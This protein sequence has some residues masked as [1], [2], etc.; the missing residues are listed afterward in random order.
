MYFVIIQDLLLLATLYQ[1]VLVVLIVQRTRAYPAG[2]NLAWYLLCIAC[3]TACIG[4]MQPFMGEAAG[5]WI[6][7]AAFFIATFMVMSWL[8]FCAYFPMLSVRFRTIALGF[9]LLGVPW[10]FLAWSPQMVHR[11]YF[12]PQWIETDI[13]RLVL[14]FSAWAVI[15]SLTAMVHLIH[16]G[17]MVQGIARM[18]IR[19]ILLGF[20][21]LITASVIC[22]SII[23]GVYHTT[24]YS[25]Y[26]PLIAS[27][28]VSTTTT[29]SVIRNRLI[30]IKVVLR[31]G[32]AYGV[33]LGLL[34]LLFMAAIPLLEQAIHYLHL[35][36]RTGI[37]IAAFLLA[38]AFNPAHRLIAHLAERRLLTTGLYDFRLSLR[39]ASH[40]LAS[41]HDQH[42]IAT[43]LAKAA[44]AVEPY[45]VAVFLP[46]HDDELTRAVEVGTWEHQLRRLPLESTA[47]RAYLLQ[48]DE[49]AL[50]EELIRQPDPARRALGELLAARS[51]ALV[52]PLV[53]GQRLCGMLILND[54][55]SGEMYLTDEIGFLRILGKQA[56]LAL[57]NVRHFDEVKVMNEYH[58]RLLHI[59]Q[60][61]VIALD[62]QQRIITFNRAAALITGV[63]AGDV[64]GKL[65]RECVLFDASLEAAGEQPQ[66]T[67]MMRITGEKIPVLLSVT[68]FTRSG[69]TA[70][71]HLL[72]FR[73][74]S[75]IHELRQ[76]KMQ[77]E[78][79]S[80]MGAMAASLAH[81]IMNPLVPIQTCPQLL[82]ENYD[83]E[84]F[85]KEFS[86]TVVH[87][88]ERINWLVG[89]M[90]DMVRKPSTER[91]TVDFREVIQRLLDIIQPECEQQ[92][93]RVHF[94]CAPDLPAIQG[95]RNQLYQATL[96]VLM[97]A[98][99]AMPDGGDL[100]IMLDTIGLHLVCRIADTG[101]GVPQDELLHI[102]EP[103][104]TTKAGRHGMGLALTYQSIHFHGGEVRADS[105][106]G[107]GLT[108]T[109]VLPLAGMPSFEELPNLA[110]S[111]PI[112]E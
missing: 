78:R 90:L 76:A 9:A 80:S 101:P 48:T 92:Y 67:M 63:A 71:C 93:I 38:L 97:N 31:E 74:L 44:A 86:V 96:N 112:V 46:G 94:H 3:W 61:G 83:D 5:V 34:A 18:Q 17:K 41:A 66:E 53:A 51:E 99:Q 52:V 49:V 102:F 57:D 14:P 15:A 19:Y 82:R 30:D 108:V 47:L 98:V 73:D 26:G 62:P 39:D 64:E 85:R 42:E 11:I 23:P 55:Q 7:R 77:A 59:M 103:L 54:K 28:F 95:V 12:R 45:G 106:P 2:R 22:N 37:F 104:Y 72:V 87:E 25:L 79:F 69:E 40:A 24:R 20:V 27:L 36:S 75:A 4:V 111:F 10:L 88:V 32:L 6:A 68:P 13:G 33:S 43:V 109:M 91:E 60:D 50:A 21:G 105:V 107:A 16:K 8:W 84:R 65:I 1:I 81:E 56:A 70:Q 58:A 110:E 29:I 100:T 35:P 89:Q